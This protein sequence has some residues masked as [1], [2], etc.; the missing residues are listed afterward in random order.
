MYIFL[1]IV[2][3]Y[4]LQFIK[5][6]FHVQTQKEILY[7]LLEN[8]TTLYLHVQSLHILFEKPCIQISLQESS[9]FHLSISLS[10][11]LCSN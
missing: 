5:C 1:N 3:H 4:Y 7:Q 6:D 9:I 11:K 2:C 10:S 8:S